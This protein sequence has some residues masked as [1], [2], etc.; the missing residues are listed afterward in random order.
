RAVVIV[1]MARHGVLIGSLASIAGTGAFGQQVA[2][3]PGISPQQLQAI[4]ELTAAITP[5]ADAAAAAR[6]RLIAATFVSPRDEGAIRAG[7]QALEA[8]ERTLAAARAHA[9]AAVQASPARLGPGQIAALVAMGGSFLRAAGRG[10]NPH[11]T[12]NQRAVLARM[13]TELA[14]LTDVVTKARSDVVAASLTMPRDDASITASVDGLIRAENALGEARSEKIAAI[15]TSSNAL[16]PFQ[17]AALVVL[18]GTIRTTGLPFTEP[19]P[20]D[21][22]DHE[23]YV[24]LFDGVTLKGWDGN[25]AI[26]RVERGAIVGE[27]TV[28][29]PSGN[30]YLAY[31]AIDSRDFTLKLDSKTEG[32]GGPA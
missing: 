12:D 20:A 31:R 23:G 25:P 28:E 7:A 6:D 1:R 29:R 21:F 24:S 30:S 18:G 32:S 16:A 5:P 27:S 9:F 13:T 10:G 4:A 8:A 2:G 3:I 17:I 22:S 15:E 19:D 11:L 26:W 14:P